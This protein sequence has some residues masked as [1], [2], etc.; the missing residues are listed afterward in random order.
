[1]AVASSVFV[2][3]LS[4]PNG[5]TAGASGAIFGV[6]GVALLLLLRAKQ[7]VRTLLALL[8]INALISTQ[9]NISW[10][11]H[12]GGFIS[13]CI[14]GAAIAYA[15]RERRQLVQILLFGTMWVGIVV[16]VVAR[17]AVLSRVTPVSLSTAVHTGVDNYTRV[18]HSH[19]MAKPNA[20]TMKPM[21]ITRFH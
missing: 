7:D 1:M 9:G 20:A 11:G 12:L 4:A 10:Q 21:P 8:A 2:Y 16:A 17:P 14:I 15:P 13:G 5:A 6:F 18:T 19:F 3:W